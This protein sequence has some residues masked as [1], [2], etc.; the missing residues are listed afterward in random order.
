VDLPGERSEWLKSVYRERL[1]QADRSTAWLADKLIFVGL[2]QRVLGGAALRYIP[3]TLGL[4]DFLQKHGLVSASGA[5]TTDGDRIEQALHDEFPMGFVVRPAVGVAAHETSRGLYRD[6]DLFIVELLR[7]EQ[8][9]VYRRSHAKH[10]VR[11]DLLQLVASGESV[12]LQEDLVSAARLVR[13]LRSSRYA[14]VRI[15]TYGS[16]V[17]AGSQARRWI[18]SDLASPEDVQRAEAIT[19]ELLAS[20]DRLAPGLLDRLAFGVDVAVFDN[21]EARIVD[22]VT[23]R[24]QEIPWSGYLDQPRVLGAY[25]RHFESELG[26]RATGLDG[27]LLRSNLANY[28]GYWRIRRDRAAEAG[29]VSW[30]LSFLPPGL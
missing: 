17:V 25:T 14:E 16:K 20:V 1:V 10:P 23:N 6:G 13:P 27:A 7:G 24:G 15:H 30:A 9:T 18:Q 29:W 4:R 11:S 22:W 19:Q 3:K 28:L 2:L 8:S 21:G 5:I 12:V 26:I